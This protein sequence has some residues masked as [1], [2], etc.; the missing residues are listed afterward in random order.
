MHFIYQPEYDRHRAVTN[1]Q[2]SWLVDQKLTA[3]FSENLLPMAYC[4]KP[5]HLQWR[6]RSGLNRIPYSPLQN[7]C[8]GT[9]SEYDTISRLLLCAFSFLLCALVR[10][11]GVP[12]Y[13]EPVV[14]ELSRE[15]Y[16]HGTEK[17]HVLVPAC[18]GKGCPPPCGKRCKY[19]IE[20]G[21]LEQYYHQR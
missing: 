7:I 8:K 11:H 17:H 19:Q 9:H 1:E 18:I 20:A 15:V 12:E 2:V 21:H 5:P 10:V 4:S 14:K 16:S 6:L 3:A 13:E